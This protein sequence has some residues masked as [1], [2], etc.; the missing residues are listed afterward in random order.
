MARALW[1]T[2]DWLL[3]GLFWVGFAVG[4]PGYAIAHSAHYLGL[5]V[6]ERR[7]R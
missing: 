5:L 1:A 7:F 2:A 4:L 3:C 6:A